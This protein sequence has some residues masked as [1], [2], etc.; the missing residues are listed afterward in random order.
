MK[1]EITAYDYESALECYEGICLNCG[2]HR[3]GCEPDARK[4]K[5]EICGEYKV[6]GVPELLIMGVLDITEEEDG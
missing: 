1:I 3:Y 4:Y 2:S 6:Y 5:C